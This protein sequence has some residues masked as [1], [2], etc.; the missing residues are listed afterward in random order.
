M[1]K[2]AKLGAYLGCTIGVCGWLIG[3]AV[4]LPLQGQGAAFWEIFWP[5]LCLSL[6]MSFLLIV[7]M[8]SVRR[9]CGGGW[10]FQLT[11]WGGLL[12]CMGLMLFLLNHWLLEVA[13]RH[14]ELGAAL[15]R[16]GGG[17][18]MPEYEPVLSMALG[19]ILL[20]VVAARLVLMPEAPPTAAGAPGPTGPAGPAPT[21]AGGPDASAAEATDTVG[22]VAAPAVA[23]APGVAAAVPPQAK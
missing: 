19:A 13:A 8:E 4:V 7:L 11:L 2:K 1:T 9:T 14:R 5:G 3:L 17:Y 6:G 22:A 16:S 23:A 18:R 20:A 10:V 12:F 15:A 21:G